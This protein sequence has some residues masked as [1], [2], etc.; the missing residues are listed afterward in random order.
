M[1]KKDLTHLGLLYVFINKSIK[2]T[3]Y[4]S[5]FYEN[6]YLKYAKQDHL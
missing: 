6:K 1:L 2:Y 3:K 4:I 5:Y